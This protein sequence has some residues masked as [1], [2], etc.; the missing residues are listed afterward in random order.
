VKRRQLPITIMPHAMSRW[1][2]YVG[3]EEA[4]VIARE[5]RRHLVAFL[6]CGVPVDHTGA[7]QLQL[8]PRLWAVAVPEITGGWAVLTFHR[9]E[10]FREGMAG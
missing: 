3:P 1:R 10:Y 5:V 2:E 6:R 8:R 4:R 7:V 9:G